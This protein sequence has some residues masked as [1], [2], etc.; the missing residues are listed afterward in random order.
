MALKQGYPWLPLH[1]KLKAYIALC[2]P[3]TLLPPI[4]VGVFGTLAPVSNI[5]FSHITT[6]I[7]VGVTLALA[8]AVGQIINQ[9][10][11][12]DLDKIV[13]PYR[14]IPQGLITKDEAMGLAWILT[15]IVVGRA[16]TISL[17][18]GILVLAML[19]FAVFYS[20][21]PL[22]PRRVHA[23]ANN[24]W[25]AVSRGFLPMFAVYTIYGGFLEAL[26]LSVIPFL[27]VLAY[28]CTKDIPDV[29]GDIRFGIKTIP[30]Q[31]GTLGVIMNMVVVSVFLYTYIVLSG[32]LQ[33]LILA[34]V[35]SMIL[36][37]VKRKAKVLE[38]TVAWILFYTG[39]G[40]IYV[41][42]FLF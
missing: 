25:L 22:S 29:E 17:V 36:L 14:P 18:F 33:F 24:M 32:L 34:P 4:L 27:W 5:T 42:V 23:L 38:N 7:Y 40:L 37:T 26:K 20:L 35:T 41:I 19:F 15:I 9:A 10:V 8:Q 16:F 39:L 1:R 11:D 31:F 6:A 21:P 13:K 3:F 12:A 28:N 2:R 30:S